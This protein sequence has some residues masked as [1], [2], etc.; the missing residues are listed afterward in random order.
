MLQ[1]IGERVDRLYAKKSLHT[2]Y[3]HH[4][5]PIPPSE[6]NISFREYYITI[7]SRDRDRSTW[8]SSSYF[9]VKMEPENT[10][11]G[12]TVGRSFKNVKSIEVVSAQ[13]PNTKNVLDEM[14]LYLC[15]QEIEGIFEATNVTGTKAIAKLVPTRLLGDYVYVEYDKKVPSRI[16]PN[17]GVRLDKLT[18]EFRKYDGTLFDFGTDTLPNVP[19]NPKLQTC[20]TI[21]VVVQTT[22]TL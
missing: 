11:K 9:Q 10:Y 20:I 6:E 19:C 15:F 1:S 13:F 14:Y 22:N 8:A 4:P 18:I 2:N 16:F 17:K 5:R 21:R 12:A 3:E 7:D